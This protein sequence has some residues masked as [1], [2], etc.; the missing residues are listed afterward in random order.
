[1]IFLQLIFV[2][3]M[4]NIVLV[5]ICDSFVFN[6]LNLFFEKKKITDLLNDH[7]NKINDNSN[8]LWLI[9]VLGI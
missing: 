1:M 6:D 8:F 3:I 9:L 4:E 5:F 2:L 7:S